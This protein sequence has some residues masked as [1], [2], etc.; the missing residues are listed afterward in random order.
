MDGTKYVLIKIPVKS[1][2]LKQAGVKIFLLVGSNSIV[3]SVF[4]T[5]VYLFLLLLE[6][7]LLNIFTAVNYYGKPMWFISKIVVFVTN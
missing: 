5:D 2:V 6:N 7:I 3:S 4:L 1:D